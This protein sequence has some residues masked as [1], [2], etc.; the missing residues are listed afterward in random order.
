M[1]VSL[2]TNKINKDIMKNVEVKI[3]KKMGVIIMPYEI[4][5]LEK[6]LKERIKQY[7]LSKLISLEH[8]KKTIQLCSELSGLSILLT[9]R[10]GEFMAFEGEFNN[11]AP[12][13]VNDPGNKI[14]VFERTVAHLYFI[15]EETHKTSK[16]TTWLIDEL[17]KE[18][19]QKYR[20]EE[21]LLYS[22]DLE[23]A[24]EN[25]KKVIRRGDK[26]DVLTGLMNASYLSKCMHRLDEME[27][28]PIAMISININDW[29]YFF[30]LYGEDD[31][32]R[33]IRL[34]A[35]II[36]E[37]AKSEYLLC[38]W[39]KDSYIVLILV[40]KANEA[41]DYIARIKARCEAY[42]DDHLIPSIACG[43]VIKDNVEKELKELISDAEYEMLED[44]LVIKQSQEY[45]KR[46]SLANV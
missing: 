43:M 36:K 1:R 16:V 38:R 5:P 18:V 39:E 28:V 7:P 10:H 44:K 25:S 30:D 6:R 24:I 26:E 13:V 27:V 34:I 3:L 12:D 2:W 20:Y 14:R 31:A 42:S 37:E 32:D 11:F 33:L 15:G 29:K 40:P 46:L 41:W 23:S 22:D 4:M 45:K 9:D 35:S 19:N 8:V 17:E 21:L